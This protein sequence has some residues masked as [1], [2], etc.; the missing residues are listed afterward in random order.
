MGGKPLTA[1]EML[2]ILDKDGNRKI[3]LEECVEAIV[4]IMMAFRDLSKSARG[5]YRAAKSVEVIISCLLLGIV[6]ILY[7]KTLRQHHMIMPLLT[8]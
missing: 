1:K 8:K 7:G 6:A 2:K 4:E 3:G 5:V